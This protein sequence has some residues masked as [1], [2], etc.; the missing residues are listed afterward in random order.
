MNRHLT[1]LLAT[2]LTV[3]SV[4]AAASGP[5]AAHPPSP[6]YHLALGDSLPYGFT[7]AGA[8]AGL[9]PSAFT[10][11]TDLVSR[12]ARLRTVNYS[13]PG[14]TTGTFI[15]GPCGWRAAGFGLHDDYPGSQ[16]AAAEAFLAGHR[17]DPHTL[18]TLTLW[19]NDIRLFLESCPDV[20]CVLDRAPAE[21]AALADR[22]RQSLTRLRAAAPRARIVLV[23]AFTVQLTDLAA[24]DGLIGAL[25]AAMAA[26]GASVGARF[27]DPAPIFNP[28]GDATA[29]RKVLCR[30]T[31]LCAE[32]DSHP[33]T[34]GH[35]VLAALVLT[36]A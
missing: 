35:R 1:R 13:C 2:A 20:A 14:E 21:I 9:P 23:G 17:R 32:N 10:G 34:A 5:A 24:A 3:A 31:L 25:N 18:I 6:R 16:L 36:R 27:A 26:A 4:T 11:F 29:R 12:A 33:S 8:R 7:T 30:L 22:L 19:G 15:T 28:P